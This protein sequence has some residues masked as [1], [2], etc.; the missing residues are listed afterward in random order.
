MNAANLYS[1]HWL[2][3]YEA[4]QKGWLPHVHGTNYVTNDPFFS[5]LAA[6]GV[7][8]YNEHTVDVGEDPQYDDG[9]DFSDSQDEEDQDDETIA[10]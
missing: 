2:L 3:A 6:A 1:D 10:S 7:S 4:Q 8:F 9:Q 5:L